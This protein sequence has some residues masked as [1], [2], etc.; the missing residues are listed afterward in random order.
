M[1]PAYG[2]TRNG[3]TPT[4]GW[5]K[6]VAGLCQRDALHDSAVS[7]LIGSLG[8][9]P[10][11][12]RETPQTGSQVCLT[13]A[14]SWPP[15]RMCFRGWWRRRLWGQKLENSTTQ[16]SRAEQQQGLRSDGKQ[17]YDAG[18]SKLESFIVIRRFSE[19]GVNQKGGKRLEGNQSARAR[20]CRSRLKTGDIR[21]QKHWGCSSPMNRPAETGWRRPSRLPSSCIRLPMS[22][23]SKP[24]LFL[25]LGGPLSTRMTSS[26]ADSLI[27]TE[28]QI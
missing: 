10:P 6:A 19:T 28:N 27:W 5:S 23:G 7:G 22:L 24:L 8:R 15:A 1:Q 17:I 26:P 3:H 13:A 25:E 9:D 2:P 14:R 4:S 18:A 11:E 21:D 20:T 12:L 16:R